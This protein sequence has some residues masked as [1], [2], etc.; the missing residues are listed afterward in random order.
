MWVVPSSISKIFQ[1][2]G[3]TYN[4]FDCIKYLGTYHNEESNFLTLHH[5]NNKEM[6]G[7]TGLEFFLIM[8]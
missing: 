2:E 7:K 3:E 8:L 5:G 4:F 1:K 6:I